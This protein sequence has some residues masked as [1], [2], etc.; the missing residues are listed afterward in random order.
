M[1]GRNLT[2][3]TL[4]TVGTYIDENGNKVALRQRF[5][6][7]QQPEHALYCP[8]RRR[9]GPWEHKLPNGSGIQQQLTEDFGRINND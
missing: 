9:W 4:E 8:Q 6:R 5:F 7:N 2:L 1:T 3:I